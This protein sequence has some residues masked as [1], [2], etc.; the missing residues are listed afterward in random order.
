MALW[1]SP[2]VASSIANLEDGDFVFASEPLRQS[3]SRKRIQNNRDKD[4]KTIVDID[5]LFMGAS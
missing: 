1:M 4:N 2:I 3:V 5:F